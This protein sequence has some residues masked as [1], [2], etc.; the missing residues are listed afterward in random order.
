MSG[1]V[2][3]HLSMAVNYTTTTFIRTVLEQRIEQDGLDG[4]PIELVHFHVLIHCTKG[5]GR[6]MVDFVDHPMRPG[7]AVWIRPGQVQRWDD[8]H[9]GFDADVVVFA[10]SSIPDLPLFTHLQRSANSTHLGEDSDRLEQ[11]M[12]WMVNDLEHNE[13][14]AIA[15]AV[16]GVMLR[17]YARNVSMD[18]S[19]ETANGRLAQAFVESV[20][21]RIDQ[22]SV[23]WHAHNIG[24][25]TRSVARAVG[26]ILGQRPKEVID[27]RVVLEA[28]RLL[29]W[30]DDD[31]ATI[32]RSLRFSE[33][34][35]FTK[36]FR[37]RTG[38]SPSTFRD[39]VNAL[40]VSGSE[41]GSNADRE[42]D[43]LQHQDPGEGDVQG[44]S[45]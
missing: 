7:T 28:R 16:V 26:E 12:R 6:H 41:G 32:A 10:S 4:P 2:E 9:D 18:D 23:A 31:V 25:S 44:S 14:R 15:A 30:S 43:Q 13:D 36:Y 34:S 29:A 8:T 35:N 20:E 24:A 11:L 39:N 27:A 37:V 21:Q 38:E 45:V 22:R 33:A 3:M 42:A 17:L 19:R 40:G 5:A 1:F